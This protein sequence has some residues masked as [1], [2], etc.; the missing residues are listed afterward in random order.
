MEELPEIFVPPRIKPR[1]TPQEEEK[2]D[3]AEKEKETEQGL[4]RVPNINSI[5]LETDRLLEV[6]KHLSF[7]GV[8]NKVMNGIRVYDYGTEFVPQYKH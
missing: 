8:N 2:F 6:L 3:D 1:T 7:F 5:T 4:A